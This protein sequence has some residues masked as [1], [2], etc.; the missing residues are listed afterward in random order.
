MRKHLEKREA[1]CFSLVFGDLLDPN[2]FLTQKR[3]ER[4]C[5]DIVEYSVLPNGK[6]HG[7]CHYISAER[8]DSK[9]ETFCSYK[10]GKLEGDFFCYISTPFDKSE[11]SANFRNGIPQGRITTVT[12]VQNSVSF[13]INGYYDEIGRPIKFERDDGDVCWPVDILWEENKVVIKQKTFYNP[14][15][16]KEDCSSVYSFLAEGAWLLCTLLQNFCLKV[17][18]ED[19]KGRTV[20]IEIPIFC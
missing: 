4:K 17:Q 6:R 19:E 10:F 20:L 16:S 9:F 8:E 15:F 7:K 5:G 1:L 2:D 18:A 13:S 12:T 14:R 3:K 11:C